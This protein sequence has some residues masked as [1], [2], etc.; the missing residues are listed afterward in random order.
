MGMPDLGILQSSMNGAIRLSP[1][2]LTQNLPSS[3]NAPTFKLDAVVRRH[4]HLVLDLNRGN[5]LK[6][7]RQLGTSRS[8]LYRMLDV[9]SSSFR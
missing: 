9:E 5:K 1:A 3:Q 2:Q 8:T 7:A 4:V 6:T